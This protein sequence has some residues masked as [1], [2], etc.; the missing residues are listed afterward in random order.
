MFSAA[1]NYWKHLMKFFDVTYDAL[2]TLKHAAMQEN[3][4]IVDV[5]FF[6]R[7][8]K[9]MTFLLRKSMIA[10]WVWY[11]YEFQMRWLV[12]YH[13]MMKLQIYPLILYLVSI[14]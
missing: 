1:D 10:D 13:D 9:T 5:L 14:V 6:R 3:P 2:Y 4:H 11:Q 8:L 12:H 7:V